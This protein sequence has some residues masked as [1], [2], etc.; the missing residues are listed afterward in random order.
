MLMTPCSTSI[1]LT[2]CY[3]TGA[4]RNRFRLIETA[5]VFLHTEIYSL[6]LTTESANDYTEEFV[7]DISRDSKTAKEFFHLLCKENVT[8]LHLRDVAEDY[9]SSFC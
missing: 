7:Y 2:K 3:T 5:D 9:L 8:A 1:I 4:L 6:F